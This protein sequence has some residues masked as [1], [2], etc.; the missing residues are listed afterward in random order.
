VGIFICAFNP[1][2]NYSTYER[3][4]HRIAVDEPCVPYLGRTM[5]IIIM[6][7]LASPTILGSKVD[8][9]KI[10]AIWTAAKDFLSWKTVN[11]QCALIDLHAVQLCLVRERIAIGRDNFGDNLFTLVFFYESQHYKRQRILRPSHSR[12]KQPQT[13]SHEKNNCS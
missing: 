10:H 3:Q 6:A 9:D 2:D 5:H 4:L 8:R 12:V 1:D 13:R 11:V 7:Q